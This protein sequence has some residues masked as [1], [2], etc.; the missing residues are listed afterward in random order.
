MNQGLGLSIVIP[1]FNEDNRLPG[2]LSQLDAF[3]QAQDYTC[4]FVIV[5]DGSRVPVSK[6][7]V[8]TAYRTPIQVIRLPENQGKGAALKAGVLVTHG[9][10]VLLTDADG[11]YDAGLIATFMTEA[12]TGVELVIPYRETALPPFHVKAWL[13]YMASAVY[14]SIVRWVLLSNIIDAQCGFKLFEGEIARAL[15]AQLEETRWGMDTEILWR[16]I[17]R[18]SRIAQLPVTVQNDLAESKVSILPN[19]LN[20]LW[21]VIKL[22]WI[23]RV[24]R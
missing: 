14:R 4:D 11:A 2:Y 19:A 3:C 17:R 5:D 7:L 16:A 8:T 23:Q 15:F 9:K 20:M 13:R 1:A 24:R 12:M 21:L 6:W 10:F 18:G 22:A